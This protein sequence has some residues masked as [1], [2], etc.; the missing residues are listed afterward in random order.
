[1]DLWIWKL[2]TV[3]YFKISIVKRHLD[4][5]TSTLFTDF[6]LSSQHSWKQSRYQNL[7]KYNE[8]NQTEILI[9]E[10]SC[11]TAWCLKYI[12]YW[13]LFILWSQYENYPPRA[14]SEEVAYRLLCILCLE[15]RCCVLTVAYSTSWG[16]CSRYE[17]R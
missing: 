3:F 17:L 13:L 7:A 1:M 15:W 10:L 11:Y 16:S 2:L 5:Q 8:T 12:L 6:L 4:H 14:S 9:N